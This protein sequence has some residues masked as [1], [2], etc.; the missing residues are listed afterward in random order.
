MKYFILN[1]GIKMPVIGL[2]TFPMRRLEL[3]KVFF[4]ATSC[5]YT[6]F[7]TSSAYGNERWLGL[8]QWISRK[9]REKLFFT[10]KLS[11]SQQREGNIR[12]ALEDS[13]RL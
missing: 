10:T 5:G 13:L 3:F 7:D 6:S 1:N 8:A 4:Q 9:Q 11:N 12:K 2:G